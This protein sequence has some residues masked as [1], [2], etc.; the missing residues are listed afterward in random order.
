[1][2]KLRPSCHISQSMRRG[3]DTLQ[4]SLDDKILS[5]LGAKLRAS[6]VMSCAF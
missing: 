4:K 5:R 6:N 3:L 1:V 2:E